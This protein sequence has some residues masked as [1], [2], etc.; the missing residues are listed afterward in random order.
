MDL[1]IARLNIEHF[2]TLL[3]KETDE[4]R[5][6]TILQLLEAEEKKLA[7]LARARRKGEEKS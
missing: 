1:F 7:A 5:R 6:K 4:A 3:I 2:R